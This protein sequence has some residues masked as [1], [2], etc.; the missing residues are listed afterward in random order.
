MGREQASSH[1]FS[2]VGIHGKS[3]SLTIFHARNEW[4]TMPEEKRVAFRPV[5]RSAT[6]AHAP[7]LLS[8][9]I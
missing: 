4:T 2:V 1:C 7:S 8:P 3:R 5:S 9:L 6:V